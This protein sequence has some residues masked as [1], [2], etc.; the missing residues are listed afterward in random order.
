M[1]GLRNL[2]FV[3][4]K[5]GGSSSMGTDLGYMLYFAI[6]NITIAFRPTMV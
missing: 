6:S 2:S 3:Y 1:V 4:V 5:G